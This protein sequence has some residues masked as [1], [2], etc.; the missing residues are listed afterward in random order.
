MYKRVSLN[1]VFLALLPVLGVGPCGVHACARL[2][3]INDVGTQF[4]VMATDRGEPAVGVAYVLRRGADQCHGGEVLAKA[5]T[6]HRGSAEFGPLPLGSATLCEVDLEGNEWSEWRVN[7]LP[8]LP[9][10][11]IIETRAAGRNPIPVREASGVIRVANY[12]PSP[13]GQGELVVTLAD[14]V[15]RKTLYETTANRAG[16]FSFSG[17]IP[18][19]RYYLTF[20]NKFVGGEF[21]VEVRPDARYASV[22]VDAVISDCGTSAMQREPE[23]PAKVTIACGQVFDSTKQPLSSQA[24]MLFDEGM[25]L[26]E[27]VVT[28]QDG[29]FQFSPQNAGHYLI[30]AP[31]IPDL[32]G[33]REIELRP[34]GANTACTAPLRLN[35]DFGYS[36][37]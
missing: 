23:G 11:T 33:R 17:T 18:G 16:E 28:D 26:V 27:R 22:N 34:K 19:G 6:D 5:T 12:S 31:R 15:T 35:L 32:P 30:Y 7:V 3:M 37:W 29:K 4:Q 20:V 1:F 24:L 2:M 9:S 36:D 13:E 14:V 10:H 21:Y 25:N 8:K